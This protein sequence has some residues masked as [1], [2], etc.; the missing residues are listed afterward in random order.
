M[1]TKTVEDKKTPK[2]KQLTPDELTYLYNLGSRY[3][4]AN[5]YAKATPIFQFLV[6]INTTNVLYV[7]GLAG[8]SQA[9]G[10]FV[11]ALFSYKFA[12]ILD[13]AN[14]VD[15]LFY[16]GVCLYKME[17]FVRAKTEFEN[18]I[19]S[20]GADTDMAEKANLYLG[21]IAKHPVAEKAPKEDK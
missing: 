11:S 13:I 21:A 3:M 14:N 16:A 2:N 15:C 20:P 12:Y 7:K 9:S 8:C 18:F 5:D 4:Q 19:N 6:S 10:D 1:T 17:Q